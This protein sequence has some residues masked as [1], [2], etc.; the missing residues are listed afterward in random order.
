MFSRPEPIELYLAPMEGVV[1]PVIRDLFTRIG[2]IDQCVTEF[3][4]VTDKVHSDKIFYHYC[5]ELLS[6]SRTQAGTP[7]AVQLLG[8]QVTP[9]AENAKRAA[10]LGAH[11]IDFNFGCPAKTVNRHDGGATLLKSPHRIFDILKAARA[12]VPAHIP[13]TAKIR[14]GFDDPKSCLENAMAVK[15]AGIQTLTVHCRTKTDMYKPPAYWEWIPLIR[16]RSGL[17]I[18]A[19]GD[20]WTVEDF[21]RCREITGSRKFML[22]RGAIAN[23]FLFLQ[24]RGQAV[25]QWPA[26][27]PLVQ[28]FLQLSNQY[29]GPDYAVTRT[30]QWLVQLSKRHAPAAEVFHQIK[31]LRAFSD[32]QPAL[33]NLS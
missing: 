7:V 24:I 9:L 14:L 25:G 10:D 2:G 29:R 32:F 13:V 26:I 17:D 28:Q 15:E 5:P 3:I 8:G 22:G 6:G 33:Q 19:N 30:K 18:V 20:I 11:S 12:A 31:T 21:E 1:D 27:A 4:R 16:E 23:P